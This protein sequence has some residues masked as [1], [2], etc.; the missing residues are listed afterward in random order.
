M[1]RHS[2]EFEKN[3]DKSLTLYGSDYQGIIDYIFYD[4]D[5]TDMTKMIELTR[6][7]EL[8]QLGSCPNELVPSDHF[9]IVYE[10]SLK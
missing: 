7:D 3:L 6:I 10:F 1:L 2:I 9:P 5:N 4:K 8:E